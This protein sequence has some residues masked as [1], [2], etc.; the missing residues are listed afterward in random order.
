MGWLDWLCIVT[1]S[2]VFTSV[3]VVELCC[4]WVLICPDE[5]SRPIFGLTSNYKGMTREE[6]QQRDLDQQMP[7][8]RRL[9]CWNDSNLHSENT[10]QPSPL[11]LSPSH[12][13]FFLPV[14]FYSFLTFLL[15]HLFIRPFRLS[16]PPPTLPV[17]LR[18]WR[19]RWN[20]MSSLHRPGSVLKLHGSTASL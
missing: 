5:W 13:V 11:C 7:Q 18:R 15:S 20:P 6:R 3:T 2:T 8:R 4:W 16:S 14:C 9:R 12:V 19:E 17:N 1:L 10:T